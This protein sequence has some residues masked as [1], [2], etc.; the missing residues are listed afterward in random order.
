MTLDDAIKILT[1]IKWAL[2]HY[3]TEADAI[4]NKWVPVATLMEGHR[5]NFREAYRLLY[6]A[7]HFCSAQSKKMIDETYEASH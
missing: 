7:K 6:R 5:E 1:H 4:E 2:T 3:I